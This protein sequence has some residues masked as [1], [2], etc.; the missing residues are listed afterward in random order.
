[1]KTKNQFSLI[2]AAV[3]GADAPELAADGVDQMP[4]EQLSELS[5]AIQANEGV[6]DIAA[7]QAGGALQV[8]SLESQLAL[9]TFQEKHIRFWKDLGVQKAFSTLEEYTVQDGYGTEGGAVGQMENPEEGDPDFRRAF[10]VVKYIRTL[11]K[12]ADVIGFTRTITDAEIIAVQGAM[13]R[14][15]RIGERMLFFGDS[16]MIPAAFDGIIKTI[17]TYGTSDHVR[18]MRGATISEA[19]MRDAA[20]L[21][22]DN[23]G[24][25]TTAYCGFSVQTAIDQL[26]YAGGA[27]NNVRLIQNPN[28]LPGDGLVA[29]GHGINAMRTS[30]GTFEIKPDIFFNPETWDV[31]KIKDPSTPTALIEGATSAKAPATPTIAVS[32]DAPTVAGSLWSATSGDSGGRVAGAYRYRVCAVN[33][34]GKSA[35]C[36]ASGAQT[37]AAGGALTVAITS[38]GG[39]YAPTAYEIYGETAPASGIYRWIT[40]V[41]AAAASYQ[42]KNLYLPG[43]GMMLVV[44][45]TTV[46]EMRTM[47]LSQL[48]PMHK[49]QYAKIAPY[50]WGTTN[51]YVVPKWYA[52]LRY[53]LIRNIGV[54]RKTANPV[55]DL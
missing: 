45:N 40:T 30:F 32:V 29:L 51:L 24:T 9:L 15:L 3:R 35:A 39:S 43:T 10:A 26:L 36:A 25:A 22:A 7:L 16:A 19:V 5:K 55:L 14:A 47:A 37:V 11:W 1:M 21:I 8:Q 38:G 2:F 42:D 53:V 48:A 18:D 44:D 20:Q 4:F 6:T 34:Y 33:Q 41:T 46:G 17:L 23:M 31:P 12:V 13:L 28:Q 50:K 49:V 27:N 54:N 52:P